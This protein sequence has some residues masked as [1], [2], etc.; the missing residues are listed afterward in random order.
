MS[1]SPTIWWQIKA[2]KSGKCL[3]AT[4]KSADKTRENKKISAGL[5][6]CW[7]TKS[8]KSR[9]YL[10]ASKSAGRQNQE[11]LKQVYR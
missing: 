9:K 4:N 3:P 2:R 11:A 1:A 5:T 8:R 6:I 10:P 7:Q